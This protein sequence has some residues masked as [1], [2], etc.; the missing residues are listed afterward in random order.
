MLDFK[1]NNHSQILNPEIVLKSSKSNDLHCYESQ[2]R[3]FPAIFRFILNFVLLKTCHSNLVHFKRDT[4]NNIF[5][6]CSFFILKV[7]NFGTKLSYLHLSQI[8][9]ALS[10]SARGRWPSRA[11]NMWLD[12]PLL[13]I[14]SK[15]ICQYTNDSRHMFGGITRTIFG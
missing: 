9:K 5:L 11:Q 1:S 12:F 15:S 14:N 13:V 2:K 4:E 6:I 7:R 8:I 10:T 3:C